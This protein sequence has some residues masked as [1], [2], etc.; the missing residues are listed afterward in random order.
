MSAPAC[1]GRHFAISIGLATEREYTIMSNLFLYTVT[2]LVWGSTWMAIEYQLGPVAPEVSVFYR[3]TLAAAILFGW[4]LVRGRRL[5]FSRAAHGQFL[6]MGLLL[7]SMNYVL[8]YY[9]QAYITSALTAIA[10]ST[11]LWM[12]LLNARLFFG[13]RTGSALV[14]GSVLGI[15]G[16]AVLFLPEVGSLSFGD[17]TVY[18]LGLA[19]AGAFVASLGNMVSQSAQANGL[20]IVQTNA[21]GMLY[22]AGLTGITAALE[23]QAFNFEWSV[24][25]V[26]SLA[27][28]AL[29]GSIIGFGTYLTLLGRIGAGKAGYA[30]V[31][32]PVVAI[33][34]SL[35]FGE[36]VLSWNIVSGVLLVLTGNVLVLKSR[37][38]R[39]AAANRLHS[40]PGSYGRMVLQKPE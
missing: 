34:V 23:G 12:N 13:A 5:R 19:I 37:R 18:G 17:A 20:P 4:C 24:A 29:F 33:L 16:I 1:G 7:F 22:G 8:T 32:F 11:M 14:G 26:G 28:L 30:M 25:Y 40:A 3:Y 15:A 35:A 9:A 6:M 39:A 2:V 21:W 10:F 38:P 27:Y 36:I 31:M